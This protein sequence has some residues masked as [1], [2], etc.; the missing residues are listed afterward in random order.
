MATISTANRK[1]V[2]CNCRGSFKCN[3]SKF[4]LLSLDIVVALKPLGYINGEID[5]CYIFNDK[6]LL[7]AY[8]D[9][10]EIVPSDFSCARQCYLK[11]V[12]EKTFPELL[13]S[14]AQYS[15]M[16][17]QNSQQLKVNNQLVKA[18]NANAQ[19]VETAK[20]QQ[21]A[22]MS[23]QL[24]SLQSTLTANNAM[25]LQHYAT[26]TVENAAIKTAI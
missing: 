21:L 8:E 3:N 18:V 13:R 7:C 12:G 5:N 23:S 1:G 11:Y 26:S 24:T 22:Q 10:I 17:Y 2:Q 15:W 16:A 6:V 4:S 9:C 19:Q 20:N 14:A 25:A